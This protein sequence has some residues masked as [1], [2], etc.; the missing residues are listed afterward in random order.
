[1]KN[2]VTVEFRTQANKLLVYAKLNPATVHLEPGFTRD[3]TKIGHFGSGD[4]EIT[5]ASPG[6]LERAKP[7]L[8]RAYNES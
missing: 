7:L 4:L 8:D 3:V 6:D 5:L 1:M 2:Y